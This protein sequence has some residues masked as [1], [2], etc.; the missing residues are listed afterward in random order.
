MAEDSCNFR[1]QSERI[2][3]AKGQGASCE[4]PFYRIDFTIVRQHTEWLSKR[5][6]FGNVLVEKR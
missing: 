1:D 2:Y 6:T 5:P 4:L 3:F